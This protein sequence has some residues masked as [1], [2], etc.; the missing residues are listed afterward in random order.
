[1][2][3]LLQL[4]LLQLLVLLIQLLLL[5]DTSTISASTTTFRF[6]YYF[7]FYYY[8]QIL[9][10]FQLLLLLSDSSD[11]FI[12]HALINPAFTFSAGNY[13]ASYSSVSYVKNSVDFSSRSFGHTNTKRY[14]NVRLCRGKCA[15]D[16]LKIIRVFR[17]IS[18]EKQRK[19][20]HRECMGGGKKTKTFRTAYCCLLLRH[21]FT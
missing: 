3:L 14:Q 4:L 5:S 1:M 7:S 15:I 10:L 13:F 17:D 21:T 12:L 9:L 18:R 19:K 8:F 11:Q 2:L 6:F 16:F 20:S